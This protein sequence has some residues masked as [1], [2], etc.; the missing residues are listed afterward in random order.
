MESKT[1]GQSHRNREQN[2]GCQELRKWV[3]TG[4]SIQNFSYKM[5]GFEDLMYNMVPIV[6]NLVLYT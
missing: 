1:K 6:T 2:D 4:Q 3:D 5:N